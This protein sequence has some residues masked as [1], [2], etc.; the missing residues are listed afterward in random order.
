MDYDRRAS[1][2]EGL[3]DLVHGYFLEIGRACMTS[4]RGRN[5][6]INAKRSSVMERY[7]VE[8]S[9]EGNTEFFD[10]LLA[11]E[12]QGSIVMFTVFAFHEGPPRHEKIASGSFATSLRPSQAAEVISRQIHAP[13]LY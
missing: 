9:T 2:S 8:W 3:S 13:K 6:R 7:A 1:F 12:I 5:L 11:C 4:D 10:R